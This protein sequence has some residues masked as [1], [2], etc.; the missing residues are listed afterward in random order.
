MLQ[1]L[2]LSLL[3]TTVSLASA[4]NTRHFTFHYGFTVKN[5][6]AGERVRVWFPAA[7]SDEFQEVKVVSA[8]GDLKL[9]KTHESRFGNEIYY[10]ESSKAQAPELHFELI[11]DVVRH[12][13]LTLGIGRPRLAEVELKDRDRKEYLQPD[14]LVPVTGTSWSGFNQS[15]IA[16]EVSATAGASERSR[17]TTS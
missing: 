10:A 8:N 15:F 7:Q 17:R 9:K 14:K 4:Q 2:W 1:K 6:P 13:R 16:T 5:V 12:E 3:L 11:Y